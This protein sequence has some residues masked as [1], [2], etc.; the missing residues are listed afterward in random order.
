MKRPTSLH[1]SALSKYPW[2]EKTLCVSAFFQVY[3]LL[4]SKSSSKNGVNKKYGWA[5]IC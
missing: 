3:S 4:K 1:T 2:A 5:F